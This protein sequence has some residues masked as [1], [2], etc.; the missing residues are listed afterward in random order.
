MRLKYPNNQKPG[1][2]TGLFCLVSC[3]VIARS[4]SDEAIHSFPALG[5]GLLRFA[6]NDGQLGNAE[7][8]TLRCI[9]GVSLSRIFAFLAVRRFV[10]LELIKTASHGY[11]VCPASG[12]DAPKF[13]VRQR[14]SL[15]PWET[16]EVFSVLNVLSR[17]REQQ[18]KFFVG[19]L[20]KAK[21]AI[22]GGVNDLNVLHRRL[23]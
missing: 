13:V 3:L 4:D 8:T 15:L 16:A 17:L 18:R 19:R 20:E 14:Q 1:R 5:H 6:R 2:R 7:Q 9:D 11:L 21:G 22:C 23:N 10:A 12:L